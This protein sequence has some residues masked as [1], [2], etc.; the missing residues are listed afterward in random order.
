M[1]HHHAAA[2]LHAVLAMAMAMAM[3]RCLAMRRQV[4]FMD[5]VAMSI[6]VLG[7]VLSVWGG[8][9]HEQEYTNATLR[10]VRAYR[11][12]RCKSALRC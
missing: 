1:S 4:F 7:T 8:S 5:K 3:A 10:V 12:H 11:V 6:I 2:R 9:K